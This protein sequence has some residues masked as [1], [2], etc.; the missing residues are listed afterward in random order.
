[1]ILTIAQAILGIRVFKRLLYTTGGERIQPVRIDREALA[2]DRVAIIVPVLNEYKRLA[3]CLEGLIAQGITV[4]EILVVDGGSTDGTQDL[5]RLY[6]QRDPRIRLIDASPI[7]P[8]WNGKVW[9]LQKGLDAVNPDCDWILTIDADVQPAA[10]LAETLVMQA[11]KRSLAALS[12]ATLQ[13]V[14]D[15]AQGLL[16]P[17]LLTT[18]VYRFGIPGNAIRKINAV[19]ANGQC[20]LLRR[21]VLEKSGGFTIAR[22]SV[23][24]D[25]TVARALVSAG[26]TIGFYEAGE[27]VTT[28]MYENW[29]DAWRN[30][31]RS[32]PM[33]DQFSGSNTLPGWLEILLVQALPLP[34]LLLLSLSKSPFRVARFLNGVLVMMRLGVLVGTTRAYQ[35]RPWSY[36]FSPLCDLPVAIQLGISALRRRHTWRGRTFIRGGLS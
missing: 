27:L 25:I 31:T 3:P 5:V 19:Q 13:K 28:K 7:A 36:W 1:L 32:L 18:L 15:S 30:W 17:S 24:E 23:C 2:A 33:H 4:A 20:F 8:A 14:E 29:R 21:D 12:I 22:D 16:H 9:G 10:A 35:R 6:G 26:Y 34:L 11:R